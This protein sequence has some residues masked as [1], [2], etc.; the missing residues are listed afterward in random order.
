MRRTIKQKP[1]R[2]ATIVFVELQDA[3][4]NQQS[5]FDLEM[6]NRRWV[7]Y[8][9]MRGTFRIDFEGADSDDQIIDA[10]EADVRASAKAAYISGWEATVVVG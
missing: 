7:P 1:D 2:K 8:P 6:A 9:S 10:T 5:H 4:E 3:R